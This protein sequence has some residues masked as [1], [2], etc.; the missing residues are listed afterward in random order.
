MKCGG[1]GAL[2]GI[3]L[4]VTLDASATASVFRRKLSFF[5]NRRSE[6]GH[7][8]EQANPHDEPAA[9]TLGG[10]HDDG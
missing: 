2:L 4:A 7:I 5:R 6:R 9:T 1:L 10:C 3:E 8:I